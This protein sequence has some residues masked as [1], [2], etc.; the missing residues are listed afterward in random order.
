MLNRPHSY[1]TF[2]LQST[3]DPYQVFLGE[4]SSV[5]MPRSRDLMI[6]VVTT[7]DKTN[8]FNDDSEL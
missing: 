1:K 3:C 8:C 5:Q 6:F 2:L 7:T 4:N